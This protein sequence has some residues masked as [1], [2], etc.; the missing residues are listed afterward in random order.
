MR[1]RDEQ[2]IVRIYDAA[3]RIIAANGLLGLKMG[4]LAKEA[5]LATGT[6]Y[7][8]FVDKHTLVKAFHVDVSDRMKQWI[9]GT[10]LQGATIEQRFRQKWYNYLQFINKHPQEMAFLEQFQRSAFASMERSAAMEVMLEP[11]LLV[12]QEG[13][14]EGFIRKAPVNLLLGQIS[15]SLK[16]I[17]QLHQEGHL[18]PISNITHLAWEMAWNSV[19]R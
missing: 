11:L 1:T 3:L 7:I 18:P 12:L 13:Q 10:E 8:Y 19:K 17:L 14:A 5:G 6:L 2:K 4:E 9:W 16:E 15:G